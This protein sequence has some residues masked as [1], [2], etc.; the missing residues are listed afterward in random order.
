VAF[1]V[2]IDDWVLYHAGSANLE[3]SVRESPLRL[4]LDMVILLIWYAAALAAAEGA[5]GL[6]LFAV[7]LCIF[8]AATAGWEALFVKA[9]TKITIGPLRIGIRL[10]TD[11]VC[12]GYVGIVALLVWSG[13]PASRPWYSFANFLPLVLLR[14]PVAEHIQPPRNCIALLTK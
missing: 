5:R 8:Y 1:G 4:I 2:V 3:P 12:A 6:T 14:F 11:I 7:L 13:D 9:G 10:F